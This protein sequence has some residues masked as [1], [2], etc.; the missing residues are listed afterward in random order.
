MQ[1]RMYPV[2]PAVCRG[3]AVFAWASMGLFVALF[4]ALVVGWTR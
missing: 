2:K 1:E 3:V 4:A